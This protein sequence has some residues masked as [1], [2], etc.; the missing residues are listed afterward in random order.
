MVR[1]KILI[2]ASVG[3]NP[4]TPAKQKICTVT[5]LAASKRSLDVR[6]FV[7]AAKRNRAYAGDLPQLS[8]EFGLWRNFI[9]S[10]DLWPTSSVGRALDF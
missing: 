3:S 8:G 10:P 9:A 6:F 7:Y 5:R 4:A 2:L 1:H